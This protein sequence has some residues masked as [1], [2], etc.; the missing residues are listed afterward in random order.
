MKFI[1]PWWLQIY[2]FSEIVAGGL[3][4]TCLLF[5]RSLL[6]VWDT[7]FFSEKLYVRLTAR[8]HKRCVARSLGLGTRHFIFHIWHFDCSAA[9]RRA[10]FGETFICPRLYKR[11]MRIFVTFLE[12][13]FYKY[14]S[15]KSLLFKATMNAS[16]SSNSS[17]AANIN[18]VSIRKYVWSRIRNNQKTP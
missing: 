7:Q 15:E 9:G 16:S 6:F 17:T 12:T 3:C 4:T 18:P 2:I 14:S 10:R 11:G 1:R 8:G 13:L 5:T